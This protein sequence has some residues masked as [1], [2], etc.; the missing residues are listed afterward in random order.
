VSRGASARLAEVWSR[1][2]R[3]VGR[4][5]GEEYVLVPLADRGADLD[6]ILNLNRVAAFVWEQL[7]GATSGGQVVDAVVEHFDVERTRAETD[8]LELVETLVE[9]AAVKR[10]TKRA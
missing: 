6:A 2:P 1:S 10:A 5:I 3:M 4:R 7:D 8:Y 9:L